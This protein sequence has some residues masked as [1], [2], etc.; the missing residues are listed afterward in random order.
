M[1]QQI[2]R[3]SGRITHVGIKALKCLRQVRGGALA[4]FALVGPE[5]FE[6]VPEL[7]AHDPREPWRRHELGRDEVIQGDDADEFL[8]FLKRLVLSIG[9]GGGLRADDRDAS[10]AVILHER[11]DVIETGVLGCRDEMA[12]HELVDRGLGIGDG[13]QAFF[14]KPAARKVAIGDDPADAPMGARD[15]Y[16]PHHVVAHGASGFE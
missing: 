10:D 14:G 12:R 3:Q 6:F 1:W 15:Q 13:A 7:A 4:G 11:D 8:V 2:E 16:A 9:R 5:S